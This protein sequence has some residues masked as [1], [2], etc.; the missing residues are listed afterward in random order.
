MAETKT[1]KS[2]KSGA[3]LPDLGAASRSNADSPG[4][5]DAHRL[6]EILNAHARVIGVAIGE[7]IGAKFAEL[8]SELMTDGRRDLHESEDAWLARGS[9]GERKHLKK[10]DQELHALEEALQGPQELLEGE[11]GSSQPMAKGE[12]VWSLPKYKPVKRD[13]EQHDDA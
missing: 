2:E 8:K 7:A 3:A 13:G 4:T 5:L 9:P 11:D 6:T 10:L 1:D 12:A